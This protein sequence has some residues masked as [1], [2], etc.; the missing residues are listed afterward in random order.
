MA[1]IFFESDFKITETIEDISGNEIDPRN[2]N[3]IIVY[4]TNEKSK[5]QVSH[6]NEKFDNCY[7]DAAV[8]KLIVIFAKH[9]LRPG[10]LKHKLIVLSEDDQFPLNIRYDK[11][12]TDTNIILSLTGG[13][14]FSAESS[15]IVPALFITHAAIE[16]GNIEDSDSVL[17]VDGENGNVL[18]KTTWLNIKAFLKQYFDKYSP[19]FCEVVEN[20]FVW[21]CKDTKSY[22]VVEIDSDVDCIIDITEEDLYRETYLL[23]KNTNTVLFEQ[24][25]FELISTATNFALSGKTEIMVSPGESVE[26]SVIAIADSVENESFTVKITHS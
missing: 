8:G 26:V 14:E 11:T 17:G 7:Y 22:S 9:G 15:L 16:K 24:I 25:S 10:I 3:F 1:T 19:R 13:N 2:I 18:I 5:Y 4:Y 6:I 20:T 12:L 23:V 21:D